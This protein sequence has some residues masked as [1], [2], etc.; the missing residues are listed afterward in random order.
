M[1]EKKGDMQSGAQEG[2]EMTKLLKL[3]MYEN[4]RTMPFNFNADFINT[5]CLG[6]S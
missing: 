3:Q 4:T 1:D 2:I 6:Q 5:N